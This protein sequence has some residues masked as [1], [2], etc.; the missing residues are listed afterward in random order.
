MIKVTARKRKKGWKVQME[1]H[2]G[3]GEAGHDLVCAAASMLLQG[4]VY[5][6]KKHG[7][8]IREQMTKGKATIYTT[9]GVEA[10]ARV[11]TMLDGLELLA[12]SYP[13]NVTMT[14]DIEAGE[15]EYHDHHQQCI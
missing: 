12:V 4:C 11:E 14:W 9:R 3:S 6:L 8:G 13:D 2:A 7:A 5:G 10:D 1:G 15:E